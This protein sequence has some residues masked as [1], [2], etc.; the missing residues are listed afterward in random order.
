MENIEI[1]RSS[2]KTISLEI[3][4]DLRIIVR[5]PLYAKDKDIKKF[6]EEHEEWLH[7]HIQKIRLKQENE[8]QVETLGAE[9]L[10][11]LVKRAKAVIPE[12]VEYFSD[13]MDVDFEKITIRSQKSRWGSCSCKKNLAFNCLLVLCPPDVLDYVVVH[14]LCHLRHMNHSQSFWAEVEKYCPK[15]KSYRKWL[16]SEGDRLIKLLP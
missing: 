10:K 15:Y 7:K 8:P 14:E 6:V 13:I 3:K 9:Q 16:K 11:D 1:I 5:A 2:R 12:R 4:G